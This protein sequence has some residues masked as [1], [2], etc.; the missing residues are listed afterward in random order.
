MA[1]YFLNSERLGFGH[2]NEGDL[3]RAW[4]L[5]GDPRLTRFVGGPFSREQVRARLQG[6]IAAERTHGV[7]YWPLFLLSTGEYAGCCGLKVR[8]EPRCYETGFYLKPAFHGKGYAAEAAR[9]V[10][11]Y[12]FGTLNAEALFAGHHPGNEASG[13]LLGKL[14]FARIGEEHYPPTGLEHVLYRLDRQ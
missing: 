4:E 2:W 1:Q 10:I 3:E 5:F 12:A 11:G 14:G 7:Q 13:A 9:A 6:E 8:P